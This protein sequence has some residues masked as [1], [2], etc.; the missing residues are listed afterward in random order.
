MILLLALLTLPAALFAADAPKSYDGLYSPSYMTVDGKL[1]EDAWNLVPWSNPFVDIEGSKKP[2]PKFLTRVKMLWDDR[3]LYIAAELQEPQVWANV[4]HRDSVIFHDNDFE[5]FLDPDGD[6]HKYAELE[7]NALNTQW[8]LL[9][10][11]PYRDNGQ[12]LNCWNIEG[13]ETAVRVIGTVNNPADTDSGWVVEIALPWRGLEMTMDR[14][15]PPQPGEYWRIN[16]SRVEWDTQVIDGK[17]V[18][19]PDKPEF[20]WVWSPQGAVDMHRPEMWGVVTFREDTS[21]ARGLPADFH[22][23]LRETANSIY[24]AEKDFF[25][26]NKRWASSLKELR[27][28]EPKEQTVTLKKTLLGW[29]AVVAASKPPKDARVPEIHIRDDSYLWITYP[30]TELTPESTSGS[31]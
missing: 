17:Y 24:Y 18:K 13:L 15:R 23:E 12:P 11:K 30:K 9:L 14:H 7:L 2:A 28:N 3:A 22:W 29:T 16:F 19:V 31:E 4:T 8:D 20:N 1:D 10:S 27:F 21:L 6:N 26:R 5:V 25:K